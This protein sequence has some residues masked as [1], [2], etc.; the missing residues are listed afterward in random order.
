VSR[1]GIGE[2]TSERGAAKGVKRDASLRSFPDTPRYPRLCFLGGRYFV[3]QLS[4]QFGRVPNKADSA[5][6]E[7]ERETGQDEDER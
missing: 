2:D 6:E 3:G 5:K 4:D 1:R 7:A